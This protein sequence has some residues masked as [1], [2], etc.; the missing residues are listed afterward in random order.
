VRLSEEA[1]KAR[2]VHVTRTV[3]IGD[4]TCCPLDYFPELDS[5]ERCDVRDMKETDGWT[6]IGGGGL[7]HGDLVGPI[8]AL[9][10]TP[11]AKR[12][13]IWGIGDNQHGAHLISHPQWLQNFAKRGIRDVQSE[14]WTPCPSCMHLAFDRYANTDGRHPIVAYS[15]FQHPIELK[16]DPVPSMFNLSCKSMWE[17]VAFLA[18]GRTVITNSYHGAYWAMLLGRKVELWNPFSNRFFGLPSPHKR[19]LEECRVRTRLFADEVK[20]LLCTTS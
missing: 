6:V 2:G 7:L 14:S 12:T 10:E 15:H 9:A 13:I 3:N 8:K 5:G 19:F 20:D 4:L 17:A 11:A 1:L 18:S 16:G